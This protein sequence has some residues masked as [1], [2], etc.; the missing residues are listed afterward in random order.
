MRLPRVREWRESRGYSQ[1]ALADKAGIGVM[2]VHRIEA[3]GSAF[4]STAAKLADALQV[5]IRDLQYAPPVAIEESSVDL[6]EVR[7]IKRDLAAS[8]RARE[9]VAYAREH[10]DLSD[11][12]AE[13]LRQY[14]HGFQN[15]KPQPFAVVELLP[16]DGSPGVDH[17]KIRGVLQQMIEEDMLDHDQ[18][19]AVAQMA[20]SQTAS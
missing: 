15:P 3:G 17:D 10:F 9:T 16:K 6:E 5:Q 2:T 7:R 12:E 11:G 14:V 20:L 1:Q 4:A 19:K 8:E 18:V 13:I